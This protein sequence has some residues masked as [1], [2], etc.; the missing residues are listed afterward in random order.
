[1]I[2]MVAGLVG[3]RDFL[4]FLVDESKSYGSGLLAGC[5]VN[6]KALAG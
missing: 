6:Q 1:M 3:T 2:F 4:L 5:V